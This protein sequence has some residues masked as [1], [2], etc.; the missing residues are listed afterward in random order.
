MDVASPHSFPL[1]SEYA[2]LLSVLRF[3]LQ[4]IM[5]GCLDTEMTR[6]LVVTTRE[7]QAR[8]AARPQLWQRMAWRVPYARA[9]CSEAGSTTTASKQS[10]DIGE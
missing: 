9:D 2:G 10:S 6:V 7:D 8:A 3:V 4:V 1:E 5:A